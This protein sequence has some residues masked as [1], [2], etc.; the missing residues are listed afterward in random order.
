MKTSYFLT[1]KEINSFVKMENTQHSQK[2]PQKYFIEEMKLRIAYISPLWNG[3]KNLRN[4]Y[5]AASCNRPP[6]KVTFKALSPAGD[7]GSGAEFLFFART[8]K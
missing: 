4:V 2:W 3:T 6:I 1:E 8:L 7:A 5:L